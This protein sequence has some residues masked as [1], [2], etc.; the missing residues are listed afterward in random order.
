GELLPDREREPVFGLRED[1]GR[2]ES[3]APFDEGERPSRLRLE[4][5]EYGVAPCPARTLRRLP[6]SVLGCAR[7][8]S[9]SIG[10][11]THDAKQAGERRTGNPFAPFDE[12]GAGNGLL[13]APRQ[14]STL[15]VNRRAFVSGLG[16]VWC[17]VSI[18]VCVIFGLLSMPAGEAQQSQRPYRI[19]W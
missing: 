1:V 6:G 2:A 15:R 5:V 18:V 16:A 14:S 11:I 3:A 8:R 7:K 12:A 13:R 9:P 19:G 10:L 4:E 17:V